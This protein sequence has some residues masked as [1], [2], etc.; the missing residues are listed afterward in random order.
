MSEKEEPQAAAALGLH[1]EFIRHVESG[2]SKI[3]TLSIITILVALGLAASYAYQ[4][5]LPSLTGATTVTVNLADPLLE[6]TELLLLA[7]SLVWLYVG[8][9]DLLF[10]R[11]M[12][13]SIRD[14][15]MAEREIEKRITG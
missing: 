12:A 11:R 4:L 8:L 14:A 2:A 9:R 13:K 7:L 10:T 3:R 6:A 5:A 15:R 1:E